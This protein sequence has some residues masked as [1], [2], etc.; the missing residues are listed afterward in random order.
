MN[1]FISLLK[2]ISS[3]FHF[4]VAI[5]EKATLEH[6]LMATIMNGGNNQQT[7]QNGSSGGERVVYEIDEDEKVK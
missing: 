6:E 7:T 4:L 2:F 5:G 1:A 3:F